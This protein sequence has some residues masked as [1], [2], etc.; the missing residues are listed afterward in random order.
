MLGQQKLGPILLE[1]MQEF[2][3]MQLAKRKAVSLG[4]NEAQVNSHKT[5]GA[6]MKVSEADREFLIEED[7]LAEARSLEMESALKNLAGRKEMLMKHISSR[8]MLDALKQCE[9]LVNK[10]KS[11]ILDA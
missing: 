4:S 5:K 10:A 2:T 11:L 8:Q 6:R 9:G 3:G 7:V 1:P